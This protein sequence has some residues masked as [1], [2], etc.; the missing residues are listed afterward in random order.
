MPKVPPIISAGVFTT[1]FVPLP[2]FEYT[3]PAIPS[4]EPPLLYCSWPDDP[5]GDTLPPETI[6]TQLSTPPEV[7]DNTEDPV[8][9]EVAG[10]VY[11]VLPDAEDTK[12]VKFEPLNIC[13]LP[14][15]DTDWPTAAPPVTTIAPVFIEVD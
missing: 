7:D 12:A 10:K 8:A 14:P 4:N 2:G 11:T 13:N 9:G 15:I 1:K 6:G 5:P 3:N